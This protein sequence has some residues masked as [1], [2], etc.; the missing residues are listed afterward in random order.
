M[1]KSRSV[2][3]CIKMCEN[4]RRLGTQRPPFP[5]RARLIF[6]LLVPTILS[7]YMFWPEAITYLSHRA[8]TICLGNWKLIISDD[9]ARDFPEIRTVFKFNS[10]LNSPKLFSSG[11][12]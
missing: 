7:D 6:V 11:M 5:S 2:K 4:A 12:I 3:R 9:E 1:V 10:N 8:D